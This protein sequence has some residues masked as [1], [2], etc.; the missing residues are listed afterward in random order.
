MLVTALVVWSLTS[1]LRQQ[2]DQRLALDRLG[3]RPCPEESERLAETVT[4]I[5]NNRGYRY[6]IKPIFGSSPRFR[7]RR[8]ARN[9]RNSGFLVDSSL[10]M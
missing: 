1:T 7:A 9:P 8:C 3:F 4:R 10:E 5:E 2:R 6:E